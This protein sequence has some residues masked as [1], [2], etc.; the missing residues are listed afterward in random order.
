MS[1]FTDALEHILTTIDARKGGDPTASWTA[2]LLADPGL[3]A[4]KLG[5]EAVELVQ[6]AA[7][8]NRDGMAGEAADVIYHLL[9]LL[10]A[11]GISV[12][13]VAQKLEARQGQSGIAE[14]AS[15]SKA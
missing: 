6:A 7:L 3:A 8:Q 11:E 1:R 2:K 5:E 12:D 14:K 13:A 10:A 9:A 15:R 4:K